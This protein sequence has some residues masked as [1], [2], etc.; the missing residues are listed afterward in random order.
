MYPKGVVP[1]GETRTYPD[2]YLL[3]KAVKDN[4]TAI[5]NNAD[6]I[7]AVSDGKVSI[8]AEQASQMSC[9]TIVA[10]TK[11]EYEGLATKSPTTMYLVVG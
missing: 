11:A 3:E 2:A 1:N 10:L 9:T 6:V 7:D 4:A 5:N 8:G